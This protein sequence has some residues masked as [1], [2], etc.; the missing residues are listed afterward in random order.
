MRSTTSNSKNTK[1]SLV[2]PPRIDVEAKSLRGRGL[3]GW[4]KAQG[5]EPI[6][7]KERERLRKAGFL[8]MP[9]E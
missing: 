1:V 4:L 7:Q 2:P 8:G 9:E 6:P 3:L 5:A